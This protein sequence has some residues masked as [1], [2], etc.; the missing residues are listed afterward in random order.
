VKKLS[1]CGIDFVEIDF[2]I[3]LVTVDVDFYFWYLV[4]GMI[5]VTRSEG[6]GA[7]FEA[8]ECGDWFGFYRGCGSVFRL[9]DILI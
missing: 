7:E 3:K 5:G 8:S 6:K 2:G 9:L 1:L 4:V